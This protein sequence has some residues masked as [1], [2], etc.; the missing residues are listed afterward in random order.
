MLTRGHRVQYG[1]VIVQQP[2]WASSV[3]SVH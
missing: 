2:L 3:C 1:N